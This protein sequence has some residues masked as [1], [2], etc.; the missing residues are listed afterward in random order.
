MC[1]SLEINIVGDE[2]LVY[3]LPLFIVLKLSIVCLEYLTVPIWEIMF[4][5]NSQLKKYIVSC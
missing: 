1:R 4:K 5:L 3:R 2:S